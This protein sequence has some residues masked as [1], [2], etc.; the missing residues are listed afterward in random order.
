M[1]FWLYS[2]ASLAACAGLLWYT[3]VTRQQFYPSVIYLVTSKVSVLV[4]GNAGLVLTTLFGRL[5]KSFFLGTLRDAE[6]EV[7]LFIMILY[8]CSLSDLIIYFLI[9]ILFV[10][11][12]RECAV[13]RDGDVSGTYDLPRGDLV[14]RHGAVHGARV[15]QDLPLAFAGPDRVRTWRSC[16]FYFLN[17]RIS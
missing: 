9:F 13:R 4:L 11:A 12:A 8:Y 15:P 7:R 1:K 2:S 14:P 16:K 10:A 5:L 17:L 3:Y 6:V